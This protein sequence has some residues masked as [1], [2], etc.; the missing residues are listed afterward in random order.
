M[1]L[2]KKDLSNLF[3]FLLNYKV[4]LESNGAGIIYLDGSQIF[5]WKADTVFYQESSHCM[6]QVCGDRHGSKGIT[7]QWR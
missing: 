1:A 2:L 6:G 3:C 4:A 7:R 5:F